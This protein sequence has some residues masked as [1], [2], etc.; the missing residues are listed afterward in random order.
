VSTG[1]T[2]IGSDSSVKIAGIAGGGQAAA[3]LFDDPFFFDLLAFNKFVALAN[4]GAP[5]A[6]R[7]APFFPPNIPNDFFGNFNVMAIVLE[8]PAAQLRLNKSQPMISVWT[9]TLADVG[10]GRGFAQYDRM[11]LPAINTAVIQPLQA[12]IFPTLTED[13]YNLMTPSTD[14]QLRPIASARIQAAYGV[15]AT[16]ANTV[17]ATVLPDVIP[18]NTLSSAG[19]LNGRRLTDNVI[20][21]ELSLLSA[22][23]VTSDRVVVDDVFRPQFPYLAAPLGVNTAL[24]AMRAFEA[25]DSSGQPQP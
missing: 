10:D 17:A 9:R 2:S 5:L 6:Q 3:G 21:A 7:F 23:A 15:G 18:F 13:T 16:Y 19:F 11:G 25:W 1:E 12:T 14:A 20:D 24:K 4:A 8:V 22:G